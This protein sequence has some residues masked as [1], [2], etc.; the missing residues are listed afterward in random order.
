MA[1]THDDGGF[2]VYVRTR[3]TSVPAVRDVSFGTAR[4]V[5]RTLAEQRHEPAYIRSRSTKAIVAVWPP[6]HP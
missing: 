2:D 4:T 1:T 6:G 5:A 3:W